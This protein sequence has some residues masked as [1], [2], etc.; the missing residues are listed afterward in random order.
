MA[1]WLPGIAGL[2]APDLDKLSTSSADLF[3]AA[4]VLAL[5]SAYAS[6]KGRSLSLRAENN[7]AA[8]LEVEL[9]SEQIYLL[10]PRW[11][12]W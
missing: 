12:R 1:D 3:I 8:A 7:V 2:K 6:L 11:A 4:D 9:K 10:L 5:W